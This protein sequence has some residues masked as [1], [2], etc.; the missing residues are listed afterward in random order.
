[1]KPNQHT[2]P[3]HIL[4][5]FVLACVIL[6]FTPF[7]KA[8]TQ[9][10][11]VLPGKVTSTQQQAIEYVEKISKLKPSAH[12][13]NIK[14]GLFLKNLKTNIHNIVSIY[15]GKSTNFCGYGALSYLF[16]QDDPLGYATLLLQ[17]YGE[18]KATFRS[19][20]FEPSAAI[21]LEAGKLKYKGTLD[22]NPAEQM[23][24]LTL[25]DH[26]KGYLNIFNRNYDEGDENRFWASVNYAKFN[27]MTRELLHYNS[28]ARGADLMRPKVGSLYTYISDHMKTGTV[29]LFINNRILYKKDHIRL[30]LGVPTHFI[31]AEK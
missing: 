17:L 26:Y 5:A 25:A 27:R 21:K 24:Y 14:P 13:P 29:V 3:C 6:V 7:A 28:K 18:G 16:L 19:I 23:W 8:G 31:V 10:Y 4:K 12:W 1:M 2:R 20:I 30:K 9:L 11:P 15:P 22:I